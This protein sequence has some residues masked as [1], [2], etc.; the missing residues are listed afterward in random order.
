MMGLYT[1]RQELDILRAQLDN[2]RQSFMPHWRDIGDY[3]VPRRPR[4]QTTDTNRGDRRN[5][6]IIDSTATLA[7]RTLRSGMMSGVTSPARKWFM[8]STP[9][10]ALSENVAVKNWLYEVSQRMQNVFLKSNLY[11]V[12][13]ILYGDMS[14]FGTAAAHIEEDA[15]DVI[16]LYPFPIGSYMLS[17]NR[18]L[19]V[20]CFVREFRLTIRQLVEQFGER[21]ST[22]EIN[23]S[24]FST[25]V[26]NLF[27]QNQLETWIEVVHVIRPNPM[28]NPKKLESKYKRFESVYYESGS[29]GSSGL[30]YINNE[31]DLFL[32]ESG[33][34]YF[35]ILCPRWEINAE[36]VYGTDCPG[37]VAIGDI[38]ALQ[39]MHKR[40]AQAI[41]KMVNPPMVG[42]SSLRNVKATILPGDITYSDER[43]GQKG[44]RPAHEVN[45]R[46][47]ELVMDIQ[48]HQDRIRRAFFEDLFLMLAQSDRRDI[49]A[50]EIDERHEEKLLALGPVLE[51][52]NQDLL[53]PLIDITF[54]IMFKNG[55]I[56]P[57]P[58]ELQGVELKIE[59]QSIMAQAQKLIGIAGVERFAG[60]TS[61]L[62]TADPR[63]IDKINMDQLVDVYA[64]ITSIP[65]GIVRSDEEVEDIRNKREQAA[66]QQA[67]QEQMVQGAMAAKNLAQAPVEEGNALNELIKVAKA[68]QMQ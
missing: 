62:V 31:P 61:Q 48:Q 13:P 60:F 6:R 8:L 30:N 35:P 42:P 9:N 7:A 56:P 58:E 57:P 67:Q 41:E 19:K 44:F 47:N 33:Y 65:P 15:E 64:D 50:R 46:L 24:N 38:R 1:K 34:D 40:K 32:R 22:G 51:Q 12:L 20:D 66:Q 45:M 43:E 54:Q 21:S 16:R 68:G 17:N 55:L 63:T 4:F 28:F 39:I 37:M 29:L 18:R 23:W 14:T 3:V 59:Y 5:Q 10:P 49:T 53:D 25:H 52:L 27:D 11:N 36:D 26:K 2:E